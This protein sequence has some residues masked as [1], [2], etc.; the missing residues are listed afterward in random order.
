MPVL[1]TDVLETQFQA[2]LKL[3]RVERRG[4]A[5]VVTSVAGALRKVVHVA[6]QRRSGGFVEA[7]EHVEAFRD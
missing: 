6:E 5:A 2:K 7:I 3:P 1:L 4:G